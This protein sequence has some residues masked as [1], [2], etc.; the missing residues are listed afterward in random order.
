SDAVTVLRVHNL[1]YHVWQGVA[2]KS[3]N[4]IKRIYLNNLA[5]R[6]RNF[7]RDSWKEYDL[8]L[9]ITEKDAQLIGMLETVKEII[10]APF[11]IDMEGIRQGKDE[12][13]VGYHIGAMDWMANREGI[14]WF[15]E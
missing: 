10:V 13:W 8:L 4:Q 3:K 11:S 12:R 7:E 6:I 9:A 15:L 14:R 5:G 1:E 2:K